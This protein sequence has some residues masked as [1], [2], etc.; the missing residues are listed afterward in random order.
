MQLNSVAM[1]FETIGL[2]LKM[3][4][5]FISG[6]VLPYL[7]TIDVIQ[8]KIQL[9]RGLKGVVQADQKRVLQALEQ[10]VPLGHYILLLL[11]TNTAL[12]EVNMS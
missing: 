6:A 11:H 3:P 10:H 2:F 9:L 7:S 12:T 5:V 4:V 8:D 1:V